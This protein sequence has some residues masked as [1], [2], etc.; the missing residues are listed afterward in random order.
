MERLNFS[1]IMLLALR[2]GQSF[3]SFLISILSGKGQLAHLPHYLQPLIIIFNLLILSP[4]IIFRSVRIYQCSQE[5]DFSSDVEFFFFFFIFCMNILKHRMY[6]MVFETLKWS[7]FIGQ[8]YLSESFH[9]HFCH[10]CQ[11]SFVTVDIWLDRCTG[12]KTHLWSL[13][14]TMWTF[15][16]SLPWMLLT[17]HLNFI[18]FEY[19]TNNISVVNLLLSASNKMQNRIWREKID[20][21]GQVIFSMVTLLFHLALGTTRKL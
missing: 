11:M 7:F 6:F 9:E 16:F 1:S 17:L 12:H 4:C 10:I 5:K 18:C 14:E 20:L 13:M 2:S 3:P 21:R 8:M 19:S 15:Q